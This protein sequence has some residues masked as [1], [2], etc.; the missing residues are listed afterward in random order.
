MGLSN[1]VSNKIIAN[2][3]EEAPST[4]KEEP[5]QPGLYDQHDVNGW[6]DLIHEVKKVLTGAAG[7]L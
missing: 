6:G 7:M 4:V 3:F 5:V 1:T 2:D